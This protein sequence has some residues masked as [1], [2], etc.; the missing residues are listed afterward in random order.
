[1]HPVISVRHVYNWLHNKYVRSTYEYRQLEQGNPV[2]KV[3]F[4]VVAEVYDKRGN[5]EV[6]PKLGTNLDQRL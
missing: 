3:T 6:A 2:T 4:Q 5:I 1:M